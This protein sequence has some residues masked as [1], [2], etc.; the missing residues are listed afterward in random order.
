[1]DPRF[2]PRTH[3]TTPAVNRGTENDY[4][5]ENLAGE[6][7]SG[8]GSVMIIF[9]PPELDNG[10]GNDS[11]SVAKHWQGGASPPSVLAANCDGVHWSSLSMPRRSMPRDFPHHI[12]YPPGK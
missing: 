7:P 6:S 9:R 11:F 10:N 5:I 3:P 4:G 2:L 12:M 1:M 8:S